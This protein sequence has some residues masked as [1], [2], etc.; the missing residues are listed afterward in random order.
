M[1]LLHQRLKTKIAEVAEHGGEHTTGEYQLDRTP[2][3]DVE[4]AVPAAR[5]RELGEQLLQVPEGFTVHPK[6]VKQLERRREAL[7]ERRGHGDR[8]GP[9]RGARLRD[10]C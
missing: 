3:P 6:L 8:L 9:R 1:T 2:S 7:A 10:A 4:T 5:L